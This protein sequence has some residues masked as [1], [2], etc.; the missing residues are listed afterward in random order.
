MSAFA[1]ETYLAGGAGYLY[2]GEENPVIVLAAY[3]TEQEAQSVYTSLQDGFDAEIT[4]LQGDAFTL[5][6][7]ASQDAQQ[8]LANYGTAESCIA[9]FYDVANGLERGTLSQ[10]EARAAIQGGVRALKGLREGNGG[11]FSAWNEQLA[12][13]ERKGTEIVSGI[14]FAKDVRYLQ[15]QLCV[16]MLGGEENFI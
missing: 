14:I 2:Q 5:Y 3:P 9:L 7:S 10:G 1:G 16:A 15:V 11:R 4:F 12:E 13:C 8:I 6:G